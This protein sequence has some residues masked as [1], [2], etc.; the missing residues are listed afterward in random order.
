MNN[1]LKLPRLG[2]SGQHCPKDRRLLILCFYDPLSISTVPETVRYIQSLSKLNID[3]INLF[4]DR[5]DTSSVVLRENIDFNF[6]QT[7]II[8]NSLSYNVDSLR[9]LDDQLKEKLKTYQ[10]IKILMKQDENH[11]FKEM[12]EYIGETGFDLILSCLPKE[13]IPKIYPKKIVGS[14]TFSRMLTGYVTPS[15]RSL[16]YLNN[17]RPIDIGYRGSIQPLSFGRLAYEKRLIGEDV[18]RILSK[19]SLNL[20]ISSKWEDR[21][22][23]NE[24]IDFLI[25]C[26]ATLGAESGASV[27]DLD[28][29]LDER[30]KKIEEKLGTFD[31]SKEYAE[32]FLSKINDLE[33]KIHYHQISP[34]HFEAIATGTVQLLYPGQYSNI[35]KPGKHYFELKRDYSNINEAIKHISDDKTRIRMATVAYEEIILNKDYWIETFVNDLDNKIIKLISEKI[36]RNEQIKITSNKHNILMLVT[37]DL[38]QDPRL[39]WIQDG[40]YENMKIHLL[41]IHPEDEPIHK[42]YKGNSQLNFSVRKEYW[43]PFDFAHLNKLVGADASGLEALSVLAEIDNILSLTDKALYEVLGAPF[44]HERN[45]EFKENLEYILNKT[46]TLIYGSLNLRGLNSIIACDLDTLPAALILKSIFKIPIFYDA[47]EYWPTSQPQFIQY[48]IQFWKD[49]EKRLL[50]HVNNCQTVTPGLAEIMSNE[51]GV[52]FNFTPNCAPIKNFKVIKKNE[53]K[54]NCKFLYQGGFSPYRGIELLINI[55]GNTNKSAILYLRGPEVEFKTQMKNLAQETGLLNKRIFFPEPVKE[56]FLIEEASKSDV[57]IASYTPSG[58]NYS[59]C[60]PNKISQY[61]AAGLPLLCNKTNYI[62]EIL[63][64]SGAGLVVDFNCNDQLINAINKLTI[65]RSLRKNFANKSL[66][67]FKKDFN[68]EVVSKKMY[69][70]INDSIKSKKTGPL[71]FNENQQRIMLLQRKN[72]TASSYWVLKNEHSHYKQYKEMYEQ[73]EAYL[74]NGFKSILFIIYQLSC[75]KFPLLGRLLRKIRFFF[76]K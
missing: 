70:T 12:A 20:D 24:W 48:E 17:K 32:L 72:Y 49:I 11:R 52:P 37:H 63:K 21:K 53:S 42:S 10:G 30:C 14:V 62:Q 1:T 41:G 51:Y 27:F 50:Q 22:G 28:G 58:I 13:S 3:V 69:E 67:Y 16:N 25:N 61:M 31:K 54:D 36:K 64:K 44:N 19:N 73:Y 9:S 76:I 26:K 46:I 8:H 23:G 38:H 7:I 6:Y 33:N 15:L 39:K 35:L 4:D 5:V 40:S 75:S 43:S 68:W 71:Y 18:S 45:I 29:D 60:C 66:E 57:G 74:N 65:D 59:N 56:N 47:H 34:R 55:W 2:K